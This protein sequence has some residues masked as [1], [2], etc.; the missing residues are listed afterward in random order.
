MKEWYT[1]TGP[2]YFGGVNLG[3]TPCSDPKKLIGRVVETTLYDITGDPSQLHLK[4][5]FQIIAMKGDETE[6]I[7]KGH[8]YSQDYLRSLVMRRS[9]RVD[10][11]S[12]VTTKDGYILRLSVVVFSIKRINNSQKTSLRKTMSLIVDKKAESLNFDQF[13]QEIV[14]GK[15]ASDIYNEAKKIIPIRHIG[16]RKSKLMTYPIGESEKAVGTLEVSA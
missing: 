8:E 9:T 11:I 1:I 2:S 5:Y 16:V 13:V 6:T 15:V 3:L 10:N 14:L 4:M 7:F 12:K